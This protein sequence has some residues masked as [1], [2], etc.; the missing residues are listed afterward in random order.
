[1]W[2]KFKKNVIDLIF[3]LID[4]E[5]ITTPEDV[6]DL[7]DNPIKYDDVWTLYRKEIMGDY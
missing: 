2:Y 3:F 7:V 5:M 4:I 1:M 6:L